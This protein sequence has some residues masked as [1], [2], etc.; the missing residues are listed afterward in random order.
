[1]THTRTFCPFDYP[2]P[3]G[4]GGEIK[5]FPCFL[6]NKEEISFDLKTIVHLWHVILSTFFSLS[7]ALIFGATSSFIVLF[8]IFINLHDTSVAIQGSQATEK[9]CW[10]GDGEGVKNRFSARIFRGLLD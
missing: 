7:E 2:S 10:G 4:G 9:N 6:K 1:M 8:P 3:L 5:V